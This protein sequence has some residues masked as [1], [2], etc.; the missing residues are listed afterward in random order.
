MITWL[1]LN[2][3]V[4]LLQTSI[5]I[6]PSEHAT[7]YVDPEGVPIP[8]AGQALL[9]GS[10]NAPKFGTLIPNRIFVGGIPSNVGRTFDKL[11]KSCILDHRTRA[12]D[13]LLQFWSS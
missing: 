1:I 10:S 9:G 11:I 5:N 13:L 3:Y 7:R 2:I 4:S 6:Q 12:E 8:N